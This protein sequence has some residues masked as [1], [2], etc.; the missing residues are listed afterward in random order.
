MDTPFKTMVP[1][2]CVLHLFKLLAKILHSAV[3]SSPI[4]I[5]YKSIYYWVVQQVLD[6][7]LFSQKSLNVTEAKKIRESLFT[8]QLKA[9]HISLRFDDFFFDKKCHL[10]LGWT[11]GTMYYD[12]TCARCYHYLCI[13]QG[14]CSYHKKFSP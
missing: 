6:R 12:S 8:F 13:I 5:N 11:P 14:V 10:K 9:V 1:L 3:P 2:T 4:R 7:N